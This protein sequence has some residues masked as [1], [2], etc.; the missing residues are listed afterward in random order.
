MRRAKLDY[1]LKFSQSC[2]DDRVQLIKAPYLIW[3][4]GNQLSQRLKQLG[5]FS[6]RT[7]VAVEVTALSGQQ[8]A[9]LSYSASRILLSMAKIERSTSLV[10]STQPK[11]LL[12]RVRL[13]ANAIAATTNNPKAMASVT[14]ARPG[15]AAS[16]PSTGSSQLH[17]RELP[18]RPPHRPNCFTFCR[19][20]P[21]VLLALRAGD[22][23]P[24]W[25]RRSTRTSGGSGRGDR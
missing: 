9:T 1:L 13:T 24:S 20:E 12:C 8:I 5:N 7:I 16:I 14:D 11:L 21:C 17:F 6:L 10:C 25:K 23:I 15:R 19:S 2:F 4:V 3:I 22:R 18:C